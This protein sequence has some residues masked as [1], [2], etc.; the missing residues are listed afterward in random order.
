MLKAIT[1]FAILAS[2]SVGESVPDTEFSALISIPD[3]DKEIVAP[4]VF[5]SVIELSPLSPVTIY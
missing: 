3:G 1:V 2:F 5:D 4:L